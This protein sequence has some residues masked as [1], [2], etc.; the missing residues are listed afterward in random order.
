MTITE[1]T[2]ARPRGAFRHEAL[3][4]SGLDEFGDAASA[5]IRAGLEADEPTLVV[6]S[7][8]KIELLR[9]LLGDDA[10][11][12]DFADMDVVGLNPARII[13]A[14]YDFVGERARDGRR[15]RGIGEPISAARAPDALVECQRHESLLNLAFADAT[16]WWLLCPY[17]TSA[18]AK[19]VIDEAMA[20][21]PW[22]CQNGTHRKSATYRD[23]ADVARP[24][25]DALIEPKVAA[26]EIGFGA[27]DLDTLRTA[28]IHEGRRN[29]LSSRALSDLVLAVNEVA[30]NSIRHGG[31]RGTLRT[32]R[33][34]DRLVFEVRDGGLIDKPLAG[35]C[36]PVA[37]QDGGFG[38]WLVYQLCDL[39]Q[40]RTFAEGS[41]VRLHAA[42][43]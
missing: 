31:G 3:F 41:V 38:M 27:D 39:V 23:L 37:S 7:R 35:R 20:S 5:F 16:S 13:P 34:S 19:P 42:I 26:K 17:D 15:L 6:V 30:T 32:W 18:L 4:Y 14:W 22:V 28:V 1:M 12:V 43:A 8:E 36:R 33:E 9:G 29:G 21:H 11:D 10:R 2:P 40:V 24:F 25:D